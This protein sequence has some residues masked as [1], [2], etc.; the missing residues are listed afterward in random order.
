MIAY[1]QSITPEQAA[2]DAGAYDRVYNGDTETGAVLLG[3]SIGMISQIDSVN[4]IIEQIMK[5]TEVIIRKNYS[6]LK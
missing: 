3:Q 4:D 5:E 6:M 1:E 2:R